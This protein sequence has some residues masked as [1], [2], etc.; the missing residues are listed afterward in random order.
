MRNK[1]FKHTHDSTV[2]AG[3]VTISEL[4]LERIDLQ[5]AIDGLVLAFARKHP[6]VG[7]DIGIKCN[8]GEPETTIILKLQ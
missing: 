8:H 6:F 4:N 3:N 7:I 1:P 5:I 2:A